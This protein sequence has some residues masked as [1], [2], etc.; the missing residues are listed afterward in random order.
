MKLVDA[1]VFDGQVIK[2]MQGTFRYVPVACHGDNERTGWFWSALFG[3]EF[4]D[5]AQ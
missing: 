4:A 5:A 2:D 3:N 1:N